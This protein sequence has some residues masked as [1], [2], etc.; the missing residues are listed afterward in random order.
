MRP[1]GDLQ[2]GISIGVVVDPS[3]SPR[4]R[5]DSAVADL[6]ALIE[7]GEVAHSPIAARSIV[8]GL[9]DCG[10]LKLAAPVFCR[11]N[12]VAITTMRSQDGYA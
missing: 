4:I 9:V 2:R 7:M 10:A 5:L 11:Y 6:H 3:V 8:V 12:R 1:A